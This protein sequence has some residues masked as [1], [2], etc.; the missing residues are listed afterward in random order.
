MAHR[1]TVLLV[2]AALIALSGCSRSL[3]DLRADG[4]KAL[5]QRD[6]VKAR[7]YYLAALE[8]VRERLVAAGADV[9]DIQVLGGDTHSLFFRDVDGMELEVCAPL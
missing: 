1:F 7:E 2:L 8:Q 6:Y 9:G 3:E 5:E 4:K